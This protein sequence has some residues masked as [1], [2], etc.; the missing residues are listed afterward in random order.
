MQDTEYFTM[1]KQ[2]KEYQINS[3]YDNNDCCFFILL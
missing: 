1:I 3:F 2:N